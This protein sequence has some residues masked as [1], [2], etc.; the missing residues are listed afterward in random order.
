[1]HRYRQVIVRKSCP[2][3]GIYS[4]IAL[5]WNG[6]SMLTVELCLIIAAVRKILFISRAFRFLA[7]PDK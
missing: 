7:D 3:I 5:Q 4:S 1:M 6:S 2:I